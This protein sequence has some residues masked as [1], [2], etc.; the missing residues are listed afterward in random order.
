MHPL[1]LINVQR[2]SINS[3]KMRDILLSYYN[4]PYNF[5]IQQIESSTNVEGYDPTKDT[6]KKESLEKFYKDVLSND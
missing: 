1:H 2:E 6:L 3:Q 5:C 4:Q